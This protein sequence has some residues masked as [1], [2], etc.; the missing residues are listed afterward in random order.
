MYKLLSGPLG[1]SIK[2]L[3]TG[4]VFGATPGNVDYEAYLAW[5]ALG[6]TPEGADAP[7]PPSENVTAQA[8][9]LQWFADN[10]VTRQL[11][12]LSIAELETEI[13][14]LIDAALPLA[15][16][17]NRTKIKKL[18]TALSISVRLLVKRELS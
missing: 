15:T 8:G 10:P 13:N 18:L 4:R 16:V 14:T 17:G 9:A 11:F 12:T 6:N 2:H 5:V 3:E 1:E 7:G